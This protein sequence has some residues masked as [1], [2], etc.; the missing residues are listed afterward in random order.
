MGGEGVVSKAAKAGVV[1]MYAIVT[2]LYSLFVW[3]TC[4]N[5]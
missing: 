5:Q 4:I 2:V 1:S 3:Y